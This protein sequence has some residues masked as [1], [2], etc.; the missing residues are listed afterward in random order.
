MTGGAGVAEPDLC[1]IAAVAR[2]GVIGRGGKLPWHLR[3]DLR[4]FKQLTTGHPLIMGRRTFESIGRPLPGRRSIVLSRGAATAQDLPPGVLV[5]AD[6]AE[7]LA[8]ARDASRDFVAGGASVFAAALPRA[9]VLYLTRV[10]AD[11][12][13][14]V[15]FL[16]LDWDRVVRERFVLEREEHVPADEHND[17][18][19]TFQVWVLP[20][21]APPVR[22]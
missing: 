15:V 1:L 11:V 7:A 9:D 20:R 2:N 19:S 22:Q 18:R 10:E 16:P 17:W 14:D 21:P 8:L 12:L 6:L 13:G 5:A 4:R 3:A